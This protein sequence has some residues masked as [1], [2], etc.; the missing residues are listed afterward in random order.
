M[1]KPKY[2]RKQKIDREQIAIDK[3]NRF[4][5]RRVGPIITHVVMHA[6]EFDVTAIAYAIVYDTVR[7][8]AAV[9]MDQKDHE[10]LNA[11]IWKLFDKAWSLQR[12]IKD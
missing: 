8:L 3:A 1:T 4:V 2:P 5:E 9:N 10:A 12:P 6:E 11:A 7:T